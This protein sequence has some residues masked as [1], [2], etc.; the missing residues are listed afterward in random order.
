MTT[1]PY[2]T[3]LHPTGSAPLFI[4]SLQNLSKADSVTV[5]SLAGVVARVTPQVYTVAGAMNDTTGDAA[6]FWLSELRASHALRVDTSY[7]GNLP[8][9]LANFRSQ[10]DG[11]VYYNATTSSNAA[12]TASAA[13][14]GRVIVASEP[15][16]VTL[17]RETFALPMVDVSGRSPLHVL[18]ASLSSGRL[19]RRM[20]AFQP[21]DGSKAPHLAAYAAFGR[22]A[23]VEFPTGGSAA[24]SLLMGS[25]DRTPAHLT[26]AL[27]WTGWD[28]FQYVSRLSAAG[29]WAHASDWSDDLTSLSNLAVHSGLKG[30]G[31]RGRTTPP[32]QLLYRGPADPARATPDGSGVGRADA[33]IA[34]RQQRQPRH[35]VAFLMSDGDNLCWLQGGWRTA[36]WFGAPE[37]GAVPLGWTF[38][39][40]AA[41]LLPNVADW[42]SASASAN[43]TF[44]G[45]PSALG[46]LYPDLVS[47]AA[48][49]SAIADATAAQMAVA[50]MPSG[51]NLRPASAGSNLHPASSGSKH[52]PC[53]RWFKPAPS[54]TDLAPPESPTV[55]RQPHTRVPEGLLWA[56]PL[57]GAPCR[58]LAHGPCCGDSHC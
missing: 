12:L 1:L 45:A 48:R 6:A 7:L 34:P 22:L 58:V 36:Q 16:T 57:L 26:A 10:L 55:Q 4:V 14:E 15:A 40:G 19:S 52:A 2:P 43:D 5:C 47:D 51:S 35:T 50:G 44:V 9:L 49:L 30:H 29:A 32:G 25:L 31:G 37:R 23:T 46:Y 38:S 54:P 11:F 13:A 3:S 42:A 17:L 27:G 21:D 39:P 56:H 28:E 8:G 20:A 18:N 41:D 33:G 53:I 24:A